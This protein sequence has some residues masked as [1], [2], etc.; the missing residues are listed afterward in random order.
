MGF[1]NLDSYFRASV[2]EAIQESLTNNK[3]LLVLASKPQG[4]VDNSTLCT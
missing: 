1:E 3:P 4:K 2:Q